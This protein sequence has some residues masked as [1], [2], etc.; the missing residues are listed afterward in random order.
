MATA[1]SNALVARM[2]FF[3]EIDVRYADTDAQG[4]VFFANYLTFFDEAMTF[5]LKNRGVDAAQLED[6]GI[7]FVYADVQCRW[8]GSGA[9]FG[10]RLRVHCALQA[11]GNTSVTFACAVDGPDARRICEGTVVVVCVDPKTKTKVRAPDAFREW[12]AT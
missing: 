8:R 1:D 4:H 11:V 5:Y 3:H 2:G 9:R 12:V 6:E 10:E 7:G